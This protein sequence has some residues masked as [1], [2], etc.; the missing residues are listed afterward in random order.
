MIGGT[1]LVAAALS[2]WLAWFLIAMP[3]TSDGALILTQV[4]VTPKRVWLSVAA[5]RLSSALFVPGLLPSPARQ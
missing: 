5:Q 1:C 2:F 3:G 4:G